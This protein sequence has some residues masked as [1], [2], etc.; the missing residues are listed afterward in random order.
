MK[1]AGMRS[2]LA[3]QMQQILPVRLQYGAYL[4]AKRRPV[5]KL[6]GKA[7]GATTVCR[8]SKICLEK[9]VNGC[10]AGTES[11]VRANTAPAGVAPHRAPSGH[12]RRVQDRPRRPA[13][14]AHRQPFD[15]RPQIV[16]VALALPR[17]CA[18]RRSM[19]A[20]TERW[21]RRCPPQRPSDVVREGV[22]PME[23]RLSGGRV[24]NHGSALHVRFRKSNCNPKTTV[25]IDKTGFQ[26][27]SNKGCRMRPFSTSIFGCQ[28]RVTQWLW[29]PGRGSCWAP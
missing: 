11:T 17:W 3:M 4:F 29:V 27:R 16:L 22:A 18:A 25:L 12:L 9:P 2:E 24:R 5:P 23:Q 10:R 15:V 26:S 8:L 28:T 6:S 21:P 13:A 19:R 14:V 1:H 7:N 20:A